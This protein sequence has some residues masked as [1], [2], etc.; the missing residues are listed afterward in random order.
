MYRPA[1]KRDSYRWTGCDG[2]GVWWICKRETRIEIH[3]SGH[4]GGQGGGHG[5]GHA[6]EIEI[7]VHMN[8]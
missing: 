7:E 4:G 2:L 5:G 1:E 8:R 6:T 3:K